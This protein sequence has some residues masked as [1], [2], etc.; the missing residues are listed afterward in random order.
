[1]DLLKLT[2]SN[3][4]LLSVRE[5]RIREDISRP[6]EIAV[7]AC[8]AN[9]DID[10]EALIGELEGDDAVGVQLEKQRPTRD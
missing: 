2:F 4:E 9:P 3:G 1:M 6:F 5:F 8:A 7:V 10:F